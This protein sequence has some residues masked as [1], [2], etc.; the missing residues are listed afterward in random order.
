MLLLKGYH[1]LGVNGYRFGYHTDLLCGDIPETFDAGLYY[2]Y[3]PDKGW[4]IISNDSVCS[5]S[6]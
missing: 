2:D 1:H 5:P 6:N 3:I 4:V